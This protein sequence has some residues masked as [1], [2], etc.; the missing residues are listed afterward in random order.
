MRY[1]ISILALLALT[2]VV[3]V[4][5]CDRSATIQQSG[6]QGGKVETFS[7]SR[8]AAA[9]GLETFRQLI[10]NDNF[11]DLGFESAE[12]VKN[13]SLGE[14]RHVFAV[15]LDQLKGFTAGGD[16]N[17]MLMDAN[18]ELYPVMV[19]EQARSSIS[20][21]QRDGKWR[22]TSFGDPGLSRQVAQ[23]SRSLAASNQRI[24]GPPIVVRV[25]PFNLY[26]LGH[27]TENRLMLTPLHDYANFNLK[28][29]ATAPADDIFGALVQAARDYNGLPM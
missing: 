10:T 23:A 4:P 18:Q 1:W 15:G 8:S 6:E 17:R 19:R 16:A 26:F 24:E 13:A 27:R 9:R 2:L 20:V 28:A 29:G 12:D 14:P 25:L 11:K 21:E 5:A 22:A 3:F 7:D